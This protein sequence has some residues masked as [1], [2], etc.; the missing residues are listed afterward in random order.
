MDEWGR[1]G[2]GCGRGV[3]P[4]G[5]QEGA[6]GPGVR[7]AGHLLPPAGTTVTEPHLEIRENW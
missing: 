7:L 3:V 6:V 4:G 1:V 2:V 5:G